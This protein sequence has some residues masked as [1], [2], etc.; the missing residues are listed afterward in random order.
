MTKEKKL[1]IPLERIASSILVV[2]GHKVLL[3]ADLAT[4]YGVTTKL[5]MPGEI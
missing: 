3:D 1:S 5:L 4:L 2:R